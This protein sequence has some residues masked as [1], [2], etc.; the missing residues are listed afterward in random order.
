[1]VSVSLKLPEAL[2]MK[3]SAA[4]RKRRQTKSALVREA[5]ERFLEEDR[6]ASQGSCLDL[7]SD[8][9]GCVEGP[10]DLSVNESHLLD[11]GK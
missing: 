11:Y 3:L 8:L 1:M 6:A 7:A 9:V 4:A 2:E 10:G 5:L